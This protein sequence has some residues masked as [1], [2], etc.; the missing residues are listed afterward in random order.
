MELSELLPHI[1]TVADDLLL[2]RSMHTDQFNHHPGPIAD[3]MR[4]GHVR[5]CRRWAPG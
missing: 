3:A 5:V 2:V 1:S 4:P